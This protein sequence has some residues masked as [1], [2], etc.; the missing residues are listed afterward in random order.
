[1]Q[2]PTAPTS[3]AVGKVSLELE[4]DVSEEISLPLMWLL[5]YEVQRGYTS[6]GTPDRHVCVGASSGNHWGNVFGPIICNCSLGFHAFHTFAKLINCKA[7]F[8]VIVPRRGREQHE[9]Y[10]CDL[11]LFNNSDSR[12][13]QSKPRFSCAWCAACALL[14]SKRI[15][16]LKQ[17]T[18]TTTSKKLL[19]YVCWLRHNTAY[20]PGYHLQA[21]VHE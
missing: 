6:G 20:P 21:S 1:M 13:F 14:E 3:R 16:V 7:T 10:C 9:N 5:L 12:S 19:Y 11:I 4:A 17:S 15:P 2:D 18:T 8:C